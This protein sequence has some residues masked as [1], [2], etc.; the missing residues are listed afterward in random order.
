MSG[1]RRGN[2]FKIMEPAAVS[3]SD[4]FNATTGA[5]AAE[6][7]FRLRFETSVMLSV[8]DFPCT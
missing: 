4:G 1:K 7:I 2:K 8:C 3:G 5:A 6:A